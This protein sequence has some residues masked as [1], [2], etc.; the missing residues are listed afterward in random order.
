MAGTR[1]K[2]SPQIVEGSPTQWHNGPTGKIG[3][4]SRWLKQLVC[5]GEFN[6]QW[7]NVSKGKSE[8]QVFTHY[9]GMY[10]GSKLKVDSDPQKTKYKITS[11]VKT[12]N[13]GSAQFNIGKF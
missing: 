1:E 12:N 2:N 10:S 6:M 3:A 5:V 8:F 7:L 11:E 13:D 9:Q 4:C